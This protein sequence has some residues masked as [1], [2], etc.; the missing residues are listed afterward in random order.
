M[1]PDTEKAIKSLPKIPT[2]TRKKLRIKPRSLPEL[3]NDKASQIDDLTP[4]SLGLN[5]LD[6]RKAINI[7]LSVEET[8]Y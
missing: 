5:L 2:K 6:Y 3:D 7:L 8:R 4:F 1:N